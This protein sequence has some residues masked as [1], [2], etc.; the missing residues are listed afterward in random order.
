MQVQLE[1]PPPHRHMEAST[2]LLF[3]TLGEPGTYTGTMV[4]ALDF[5]GCFLTMVHISP[6]KIQ[7]GSL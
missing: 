1:S 3:H 6:A 5:L 7:T 4:R 2:D